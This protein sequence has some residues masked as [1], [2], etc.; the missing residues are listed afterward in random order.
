LNRLIYNEVLKMI[1]NKR[2]LVILLILLILIPLFTYAQYRN[3]AEQ[4]KQSGTDDWRLLL[5][6]QI[7][8]QQNRLA[9]SRIP[10]EWKTWAKINIEQQQYYLEHNI[11]PA[12]PGAPTFLRKF[13]EQSSSL[14][15]PLLVVVLA[16]DIVSGEYTRGTIKLLLTRPV[17]RWKILLSKY[18]AL[19]LGI[20]LLLLLT[21]VTGYAISGIAFGYRGWSLPVL[22]GFQIQGDQ[23]LTGHVR[24]IPQWKYI[25]MAFGLVWF[26]SIVV[27][28]LSFMVSVLV[29]STAAG[30]GILLA[31]II[32]GNLLMQMAPSWKILKYFAFTH[33]S[34][35]DYLAG[36]PMM[37]EDMSFPFSLFI[38]SIWALAALCISWI[39]FVR[40]DILS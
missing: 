20:S 9:S 27:G 38:L 22:T 1:K 25:F 35:T 32:S 15:L 26:S 28:T 12:A 23:L 18:I 3:T 11:N 13:I 21:A 7:V 8:D 19:L 17:P 37:M 36:K 14:F 31:A 10:E 40:K 6:Q 33:L 30:I 24:L 39:T 29:R 4:I 34:L 2:I 16:S 5:Q